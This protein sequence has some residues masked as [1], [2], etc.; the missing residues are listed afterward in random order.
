MKKW[1]FDKKSCLIGWPGLGNT[2][3]KPS[4]PKNKKPKPPPIIQKEPEKCDDCNGS[5]VYVGI[6]FYPA[7]D[8]KACEGK[9]KA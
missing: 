9:G 1:F 8:C 4:N 3:V 6:G 7:E 5:G 2:W